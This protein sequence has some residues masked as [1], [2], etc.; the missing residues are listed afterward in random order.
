[1][2]LT[3]L[4]LACSLATF[5]LTSA[6]A[7]HSKEQLRNEI[8]RISKDAD[9][10]VGVAMEC[11]EDRDTLT[12]N[13]T[14]RFPMQ[15][16][17]KFPLALAV[18]HEVGLGHISLDSMIALDSNNLLDDTYS[19]MRD[20]YPNGNV[21]LSVREIMRYMVS[22][23]DNNACDILFDVLGGP[24]KAERFIRSL[25]VSG[26]AIATTE[27]DMHRKWSKQ[28]LNWCKPNAMLDLLKIFYSGKAVSP[29]SSHLLMTFML[30]STTQKRIGKQLP[31]NAIVAH[32][33]GTSGYSKQHKTAAATND[34]GIIT[35]PNGKH[36]ALVVYVSMSK[37]AD[38]VPEQVIG[39]IANA[40]WKYYER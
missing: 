16:V 30:E 36:I 7:Q 35:L 29:A 19:P 2:S 9:G 26:I 15:S 40:I 14:K 11:I 1:M 23:S 17:Y 39:H 24:K 12:L 38:D 34:V 27:D 25:G 5:A 6:T 3:R 4:C 31:P 10:I 21:R 32:K 33:S 18:L 8:A 13:G 28:F 37:H 22:S 20:K